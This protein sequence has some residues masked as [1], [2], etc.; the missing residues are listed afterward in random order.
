MKC[1][2]KHN[3]EEQLEVETAVGKPIQYGIQKSLLINKRGERK[4]KIA[5]SELFGFPKGT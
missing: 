4:Q 3:T 5:T 1:R 2:R